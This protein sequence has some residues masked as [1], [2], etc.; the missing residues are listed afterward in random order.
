[1]TTTSA[2][3]VGYS[4]TLTSSSVTVSTYSLSAYSATSAAPAC[5]TST[6]SV[7]GGTSSS[8]TCSDSSGATYQLSC[9]TAYTGTVIDTSNIDGSRKR[10]PAEVPQPERATEPNYQA[11]LNL[12]DTYAACVGVNYIGTNCTLFSQIT[13][14]VPAAGAIA[15]GVITSAA[16]ASALAAYSTTST[17][18]GNGNGIQSYAT[19]GPILGTTATALSSSTSTSLSTVTICEYLSRPEDIFVTLY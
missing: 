7:C 19:T 12:C 6:E 3:L 17:S 14:T 5:P 11:C 8:S 9:G 15:G 4:S 16:S 13:G 18:S 2:S 1:M 10:A